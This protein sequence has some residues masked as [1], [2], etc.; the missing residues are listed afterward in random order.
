L[1]PIPIPDE[2][3]DVTISQR[4]HQ[5]QLPHQRLL[6]T[7]HCSSLTF[8]RFAASA[9]TLIRGRAEGDKGSGSDAEV[10]RNIVG[11]RSVLGISWKWFSACSGVI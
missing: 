5:P 2:S 1:A 11:V 3:A 7:V 10:H 9:A 8:F 4:R 6:W